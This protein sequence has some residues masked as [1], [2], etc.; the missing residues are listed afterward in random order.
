MKSWRIQ[1]QYSVTRRRMTL[2]KSRYRTSP[3]IEL[4]IGQGRVRRD[5][6]LEEVIGGLSGLMDCTP[7]GD[8][9]QAGQVTELFEGMW[10]H[11]IPFFAFA[12]R[13]SLPRSSP[14]R[15]HS[16]E[17]MNSG[18]GLRTA[19]GYH[20]LDPGLH[21]GVHFPARQAGS[22]PGF[23]GPVTIFCYVQASVQHLS[24][25]ELEDHQ[26]ILREGHLARLGA[27]FRK[28]LAR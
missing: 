14:I 25:G 4:G 21:T 5:A 19:E 27:T 28:I 16:T 24:R 2:E 20:I 8:I 1:K 12:S 17:K 18:L 3:L 22:H 15:C 10:I 23:R 26:P 6:V 9:D 13:N 7:T 11:A